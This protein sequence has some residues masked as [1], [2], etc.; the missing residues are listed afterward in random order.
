M[1]KKIQKID[2]NLPGLVGIEERNQKDLLIYS[3]SLC[4]RICS[5]RL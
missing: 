3:S 4:Y 1:A 2:E 5:K